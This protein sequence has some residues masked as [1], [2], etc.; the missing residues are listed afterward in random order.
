MAE[1][2]ATTQQIMAV[3]GHTTLSEAERY[4]RDADQQRLAIEAIATLEGR[5]R[6]RVTQTTPGQ[7]GEIS[8]INGEAE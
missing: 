1:A 4:T 2:G 5:N 8:K 6:N 3:L 7:F